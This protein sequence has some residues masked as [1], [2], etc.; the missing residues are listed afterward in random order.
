MLNGRPSLPGV[1]ALRCVWDLLLMQPAFQLASESVI[2][3]LNFFKKFF[4]SASW[5][6]GS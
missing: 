1:K 6:M 3:Y 4:D 5:H 2:S